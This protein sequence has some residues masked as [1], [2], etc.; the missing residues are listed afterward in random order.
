MTGRLILLQL[1]VIV[2]VFMI[3]LGLMSLL[4]RRRPTLGLH[5]GKLRA[6]ANSPN[7]VSSQ[8]TKD[9]QRV[10][11]FAYTVDAST[12]FRL[13]KEAI[14]TLPRA[15]IIDETDHYLRVE[16][17]SAFFRFLDDIE[18]HLDDNEQVIHCRAAARVGYSEHGR[19][20]SHRGSNPRR[21]PTGHSTVT[22][23][24]RKHLP[25]G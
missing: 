17:S 16:T 1:L 21:I 25:P 19:Q 9:D 23:P 4:S 6:L 13:L 24:S 10:E 11:P 14:A 2:C 3:F 22:T 12:S 7:G 20:S 18:F 15:N 5:E 8:A